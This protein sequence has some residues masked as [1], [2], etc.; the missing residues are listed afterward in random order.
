ML[1]IQN[2]ENKLGRIKRKTGGAKKLI[3]AFEKMTK[4]ELP[5]VPAKRILVYFLLLLALGPTLSRFSSNDE[6]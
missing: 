2:K 1:R 6:S 4:E 5:T 3:K